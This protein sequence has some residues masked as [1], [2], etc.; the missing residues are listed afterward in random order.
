MNNDIE[1]LRQ[2][3]MNKVDEIINEYVS[4]D[5]TMVEIPEDKI[6]MEITLGDKDYV[7]FTEDDENAEEISM[8]FAKASVIEGKRILRNIEDQQ[9]Y[10]R[11]AE[12][13]DRRLAA[14]SE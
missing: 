4:N 10:D 5:N 14:I 6:Y 8:M 9:E 2:E 13:F 12:E 1:N 11:V 3:I 7:A